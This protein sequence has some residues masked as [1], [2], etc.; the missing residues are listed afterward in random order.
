MPALSDQ[1]FNPKAWAKL[2]LVALGLGAVLAL[3]WA[4]FVLYEDYVAAPRLL[5]RRF[6]DPVG[7]IGSTS[8]NVAQLGPRAVP[9]LLEDY[10]AA[11][12]L[13]RSKSLELLST[14][15]DP[16]VVP[17]LQ[18]GLLDRDVGVRL[19]AMAGLARAGNPQGASAL[20]PMATGDDDFLR[21]RAIVTLGIIGSA[22]DSARLVQEFASARFEDRLV[23][24]WAAGRILRRLES[25]AATGYLA[26]S[27][28]G[29]TDEQVARI[30]AEVDMLKARLI[31]GR[32][33][34]VHGK[35]L[36]EL[37]DVGFGT[38]DLAHQIA[39]QVLAVHGP[40]SA[41][42]TIGAESLAAPR[43]PTPP[44]PAP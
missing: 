30:Q 10:R 35:R 4:S 23:L 20:W 26:A 6:H 13:L 36:A 8:A 31:E 11:E 41:L 17:A 43:R 19:A 22:Q 38:W 15:A 32:D 2:A 25:K 39:A 9:Q 44:S 37:T 12:P 3:V 27:P 7:R 29:D 33:V 18:Q 40:L 28:T 34:A 5:A 14:I 24:A 1:S 42:G 21:P 16:R